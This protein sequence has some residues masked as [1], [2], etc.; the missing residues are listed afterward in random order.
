MHEDK[1]IIGLNLNLTLGVLG[2]YSEAFAFP[3]FQTEGAHIA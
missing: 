3:Y 1:L 2:S